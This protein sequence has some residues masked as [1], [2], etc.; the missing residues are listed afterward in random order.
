MARGLFFFGRPLSALSVACYDTFTVGNI[1]LSSPFVNM[2]S[3][4]N[5]G[6]HTSA[7]PPLHFCGEER[8]EGRSVRPAEELLYTFP[9][10]YTAILHSSPC[11]GVD[12][13]AAPILL[14]CLRSIHISAGSDPDLT[15]LFPCSAN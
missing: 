8:R 3:F 6:A 2:S 9:A 4:R 15:S 7:L 10:L 1:R 14:S 12:R 5:D 13:S 11:P